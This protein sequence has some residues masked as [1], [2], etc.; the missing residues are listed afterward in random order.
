MAKKKILVTG[1]AGFVGSNLADR[2]VRAGYEVVGIDNLSQGFIEQVP[3]EVDFHKLDVRSKD[4]IAPLF[5]GIDVVFHLAAKTNV[6]ECQTAP[7]E[8][9]DN[10]VMG[11]LSVFDA[12]RAAGVKRVIYVESSAIYE[13]STKLPTPE[14]DFAPQTFYAISKGV[15]HLFAKGYQE[16]FGMKMIGLRYFNVYGPRQDYR[17]GMPPLMSRFIIKLLMG[18]KKLPVFGDGTDR[19]DYVHVDDV[20]DLHMI[21][22]ENDAAVGDELRVLNVGSGTNNSILEIKE[23]IEEILG[24]KSEAEFMP[25]IPGAAKATLADISSAQKL[26]WQPKASLKE[27]LKGMVAYIKDQIAKGNI[28]KSS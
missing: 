23:Y 21:L 20:N 5:K 15:D 26:G 2:L 11:T 7:Y 1:V 12:C 13:G 24:V 27:G 4:E 22:I 6:S 19:R 18:E 17:R 3:K 14:T 16:F 28:T 9:A 25:N 10:N 8:T